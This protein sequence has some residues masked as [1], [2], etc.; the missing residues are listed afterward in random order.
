MSFFPSG[1]SSLRSF[2]RLFFRLFIVSLLLWRAFDCGGFVNTPPPLLLFPGEPTTRLWRPVGQRAIA[3][4]R[5][6]AAAVPAPG[7]AIT[8]TDGDFEMWS[9]SDLPAAEGAL[10]RA[11]VEAA[12]KHKV[13]DLVCLIRCAG[14][15][16]TEETR[17]QERLLLQVKRGPLLSPH[18]HPIPKDLCIEPAHME[19]SRDAAVGAPT[20]RRWGSERNKEDLLSY[21]WEMMVIA[22]GFSP[23]HLDSVAETVIQVCIHGYVF[24]CPTA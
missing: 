12:D 24:L 3:R 10:L 1:G 9:L 20:R 17:E 11:A 16:I 15:N 2:F 4:A 13:R 7:T 14:W 8:T 18:G 23:T 5:P 21:E 6:T 19:P 22:T